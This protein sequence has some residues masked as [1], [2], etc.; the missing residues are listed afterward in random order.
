MNNKKHRI[1]KN[2]KSIIFSITAFFL[3]FACKNDTSDPFADFNPYDSDLG[4]RIEAYQDAKFPN[5]ANSKTG[6]PALYIDF[7]TGI[8]QA[9]KNPINSSLLKSV[10]GNLSGELDVFELNYDSIRKIPSSNP[11]LVGR[12][13]VDNNSYHGIYAPI[14]DAVT[15]IVSKNNDALLVTDFEE[16]YPASSG[17]SEIID[18]PYLKESFIKWL[19]KGNSIRFYISNYNENGVAKKLYFTVFNCGN[20]SESGMIS[21]VENSLGSLPHFD[22]SNK[23]YNL[24][25][26]YGGEKKGGIYYDNSVQDEN[27]KNVLELNKESYINGLKNNNNFE[28]YQFNLD[29]AHI[30]KA[31]SQMKIDDFFRKLFID[32]S[33][34]D[35]YSLGDLVVKVYDVT[36]DFEYFAKCNEANDSKNIPDTE[37]GKDGE[38]KFKDSETNPIALSCYDTKGK[39]LDEWIYKNDKVSKELPEVFTFN[40]KL[41]ENNKTDNNKKVELAVSFDTK[42]NLNNIENPQGLIR[43][44]I[45][46]NNSNPSTPSDELFKWQS[47]TK[48]GSQNVAL[49]ESIK[50]TLLDDK[51]KPTNKV[52]YSYY[53]KT[54]NNK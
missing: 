34:E 30:E 7:S 37:K 16:Y 32:L 22:L 33:N 38:N 13:V 15:Q 24:S 21:K 20:L 26:E 49:F 18:I 27:A 14:K 41:F 25:Q 3:F 9:F 39:I 35:S 4:K 19:S 40:K 5:L 53:I 46:I 50:N 2:N 1:M 36:D 10:Y 48:K 8:F 43:V 44:D 28:F 31:K 29:W 52:I 45:V 6:N 23:S 47:T 42:F 12:M 17:R 51:V 11:D 54:N